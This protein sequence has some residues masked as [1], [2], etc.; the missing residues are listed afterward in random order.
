MVHSD[1]FIFD[2]GIRITLKVPSVR[3]F[4]SKESLNGKNR[5]SGGHPRFLSMFP[6]VNRQIESVVKSLRQ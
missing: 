1:L 3:I 4:L 2:N 5:L 6:S